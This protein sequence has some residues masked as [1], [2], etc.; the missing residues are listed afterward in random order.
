LALGKSLLDDGTGVRQVP[1]RLSRDAM[2]RNRRRVVPAVVTAHPL[3]G[4]TDP[5]QCPRVVRKMACLSKQPARHPI[6]WRA[7]RVR[8]CGIRL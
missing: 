1:N 6:G 2:E 3:G 7:G 5:V 8:V 4:R